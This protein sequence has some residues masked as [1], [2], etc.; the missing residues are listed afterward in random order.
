MT[1]NEFR[2]DTPY[3]PGEKGCRMIWTLNEDEDKLSSIKISV[4]D[5]ETQTHRF[6]TQEEI[7][8]YYDKLNLNKAN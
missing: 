3:L 5:V 4:V 6:L 7:K 2:I 8:T 1:D